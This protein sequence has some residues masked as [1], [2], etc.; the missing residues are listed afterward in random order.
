MHQI[1]KYFPN[2]TEKQ[3][4][5]M[6]ELL[7]NLLHRFAKVMPRHFFFED[8]IP[9]QLYYDAFGSLP[10]E[11]DLDTSRL[12]WFAPDPYDMAELLFAV[13]KHMPDAPF[14]LCTGTDRS[15]WFESNRARCTKFI[16]MKYTVGEDSCANV[17][18]ILELLSICGGL[19]WAQGPDNPANKQETKDND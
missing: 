15:V 3:T 2:L 9:D 19:E 13:W 4:E 10:E 11:R 12:S 18:D 16:G 14:H 7:R 8:Q 1:I 5:Q 17:G 6:E